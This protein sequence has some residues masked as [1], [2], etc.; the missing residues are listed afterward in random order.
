MEA[1]IVLLDRIE[2]DLEKIVN[3]PKHSSKKIRLHAHPFVAA[4]LMQGMKSVRFHWYLKHKKWIKVIPRDAYTYL[5]YR[6][7]DNNGKVIHI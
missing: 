1:P 2:A 5:H 3:H 7:F 4:Y 6:F